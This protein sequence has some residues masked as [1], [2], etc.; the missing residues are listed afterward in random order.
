MKVREKIAYWLDRCLEGYK[1]RVIMGTIEQE[2]LYAAYS[3]VIDY[4]EVYNLVLAQARWVDYGKVYIGFDRVSRVL[5]VIPITEQEKLEFIRDII[6]KDVQS[7]SFKEPVVDIFQPLEGDAYLKDMVLGLVT[8]DKDSDNDQ[9]YFDRKMIK[10]PRYQIADKLEVLTELNELIIAKPIDND[11]DVKKAIR[12]LK[13]LGFSDKLLVGI[14]RELI[15]EFGKNRATEQKVKK[16]EVA[17]PKIRGL[18]PVKKSSS[19]IISREYRLTIRKI[20]EY[21]DLEKLVLKKSISL[22]EVINVVIMMR[23]IGLTKDI[24]RK[25]IL[26][27]EIARGRDKVNP[28]ALYTEVYEKLCYYGQDDEELQRYIAEIND[29]FKEIFIASDEDY[30]FWKDTIDETLNYALK[31][32]PKTGKYELEKA[33]NKRNS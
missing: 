6:S 29:Y 4:K 27:A 26:Q 18:G 9:D 31:L 13:K 32:V 5:E 33:E 19:T 10:V 23:N 21:F 17:K 14:R 8:G 22:T 28:L 25:F 12:A 7:T 20:E 24:I 15:K 2:E 1:I 16:T 30:A 11:E 3:T